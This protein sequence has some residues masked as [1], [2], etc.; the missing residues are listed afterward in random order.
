MEDLFGELDGAGICWLW[1]SLVVP[2]VTYKVLI[3]LSSLP[4]NGAGLSIS[5]TEHPTA[6]WTAQQV[7]VS[8]PWG[9]GPAVSV[10]AVIG[11]GSTGTCF[12]QPLQHMGIKERPLP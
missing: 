8:L 1:I 2:T 7:V 12:R 3:M 9:R 6:L 10:D 11:T 5:I 4:T